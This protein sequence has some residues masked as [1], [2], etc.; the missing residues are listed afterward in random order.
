LEELLKI[1]QLSEQVASAIAAGEVIERPVSVVKELIENSID[2]KASQILIRIEDGGKKLVEVHDDGIGIPANELKLAVARYST[3]KLRSVEDLFEIETLGF[4]GEALAS[5]G[6]VSKLEI[7]S[8][9]AGE[10]AAGK[11]RVEGRDIGK[12]EPIGSARGTI[13]RVRN[14][15]FNTPARRK[16]LKT[17]STEKRW[18]SRLVSRY[19]LVNPEI[20]FVLESGGRRAFFAAGTGEGLEVLSAVFGTEIARRMIALVEAPNAPFQVSGYISA[21]DLNRSN[22]NQLNLFVNRRWIKDP[23]LAAAVLQAYHGLLMV[24]RFPIVVLNLSLPPAAVDVNVHPAK[25]E[26]RFADPGQIFTVVQRFVRAT[27]LGQA[28]VPAMQGASAFSPGEGMARPLAPL[29][30]PEEMRATIPASQPSLPGAEIP[31]LRAVGQVGA[32][33]LVAEGPDGLYLIDQHAAHERVLYESLTSEMENGPVARQALLKAVKVEFT[34]NEAA[35]L[36]ENL[37]GMSKLGFEVEEFGGDSFLIRSVPALLVDAAPET[38][39][40]AV[41]EEFEEDES[42]LQKENEKRLAARVCKSAAIR[43]G[44]ILS[45]EEQRRL[46]RDLEACKVPRNCPHGRPTMI[47]LSVASLERQFGRR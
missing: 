10:E 25:A 14:L 20:R 18:I 45:L 11:L 12:V 41:V 5:I 21:P 40:R 44:Q 36:R 28:P 30:P 38:A 17:D 4:R 37:L 13:I 35:I 33:F 43:T 34:L 23:K 27:L 46:I 7:I 2:A 9:P 16:Y 42:P 15:F 47:H 8:R 29:F 3:S 6:A 24:G 26:V 22:R 32:A 19:A 39:L 31:L 1:V